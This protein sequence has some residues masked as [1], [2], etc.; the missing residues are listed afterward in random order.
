MLFWVPSRAII[1]CGGT[2]FEYM[3]FVPNSLFLCDFKLSTDMALDFRDPNQFHPQKG[4]IFI[5]STNEKE[6]RPQL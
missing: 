1:N 4:G 6:W 2:D 3:W 5:K